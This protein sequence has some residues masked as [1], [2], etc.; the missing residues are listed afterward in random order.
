[1]IADAME[2]GSTLKPLVV[3]GGLRD[4]IVKPGTRYNCEGGRMKV[5]DKWI[6]EADAHHA[7][8][9]LTVSEILAKSSN[10]G[11][12]K[13]AFD[14]G[15]ERVFRTLN[16]F[17]F[18]TKTDI[19]L[20]GE[21]KGI[22]NP[23]PWRS[24]LLS[25]VAFGQGIAVTP[26]QMAAAYAAIANGGILR[27]P[28]LVKGV[29]LRDEAKP[30]EFH[31]EDVRRVLSPTEAATMRL[32][33]ANATLPNSTGWNARIPGYH[34]AG[35][36]GTAQKPDF[37]R[38]GYSKTAYIS[39]FAGF[40]PAGNPRYVLYLAID[41]PKKGYYGSQVAAPLFARMAQ[42]LVRRAGLP[43]VM[44]TESNVISPSE[45][46][47]TRLQTQALADLKRSGT[48]ADPNA[49][50][51]LVGLTLREAMVKI[52]GATSKVDVRGH[53]LVVRTVPAAGSG[54]TNAKR[55]TLVLE[56]PD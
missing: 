43:P 23:L 31:A 53:G 30:R 34:V 4:G 12:A 13:I 11:V 49:F 18:G 46:K 2:P 28:L 6:T 25:N 21:A 40:V 1:L 55:V 15:D 33:L 38:G 39:S 3:A 24:H 47:L 52:R 10:I 56:N 44:I 17:G 41:N 50:P 26:L 37:I 51:N 7:F 45:Q 36:T 9:T 27:K 29:R 35:K 48:E 8:T 54:L 22:V 42:Y 32:M 5:G 20:P 14:M 16:D 19:G